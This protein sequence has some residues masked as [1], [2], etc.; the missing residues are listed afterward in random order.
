MRLEIARSM[1]P[2]D[3]VCS[4]FVLYRLVALVTLFGAA[5]PWIFH[6]QAR[7]GGSRRDADPAP[8]L[9]HPIHPFA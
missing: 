9:P 5:L 1:E 2:S 8:M 3:I 6:D 7:G 4:Y